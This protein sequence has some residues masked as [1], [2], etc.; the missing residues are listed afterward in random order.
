MM[1]ALAIS[2]HACGYLQFYQAMDGPN[3]VNNTGWRDADLLAGE[4][5]QHWPFHLSNQLLTPS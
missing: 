5:D 2:Q 4:A 1:F 3:W